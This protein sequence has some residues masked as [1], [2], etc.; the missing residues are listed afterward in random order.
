MNEYILLV[1]IVEFSYWTGVFM[2]YWMGK[3]NNE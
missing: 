1:I 3:E 2:G